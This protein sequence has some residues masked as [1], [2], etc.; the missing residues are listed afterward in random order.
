[1][2]FPCRRRCS[3]F[4]LLLAFLGLRVIADA[5]LEKLTAEEREQ[6]RNK[7]RR[8][9]KKIREAFAVWDE[10]DETA[11]GVAEQEADSPAAQ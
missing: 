10:E 6:L 4:R 11:A 2:L 1:M 9:R 7:R 8:F 3:L 5:R